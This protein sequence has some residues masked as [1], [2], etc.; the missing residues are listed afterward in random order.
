MPKIEIDQYVNIEYAEVTNGKKITFQDLKC[1]CQKEEK[2]WL[3]AGHV[4]FF[5]E[6]SHEY[7]D[8]VPYPIGNY[9]LHGEY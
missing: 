8:G 4:W 9:K 2:V 3:L 5:S 6:F 1:S 7:W